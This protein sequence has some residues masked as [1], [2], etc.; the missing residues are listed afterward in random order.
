MHTGLG[1]DHSGKRV[2]DQNRRAVPSIQHALGGRYRFGQRR[3]RILYGRGVEPRRL[4]PLSFRISTS[5][6]RTVRAQAPR[7]SPFAGVEFAPM[8][9]VAIRSHRPGMR[10]VEKARLLIILISPPR[11]GRNIWLHGVG[12]AE[13][14]R[15]PDI[16]MSCCHS[17]PFGRPG[18]SALH[19]LKLQQCIDLRRTD[20]SLV[21]HE[22]LVVF[23]DAVT[24]VEIVDHDPEE[25]LARS[26]EPID[27]LKSCA[28]AEVKARYRVDAAS[29]R[30]LTR[31]I[32]RAKLHQGGAQ[33]LALRQ[34]MP[35][36]IAFEFRATTRRRNRFLPR[37][38]A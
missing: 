35:P 12:G 7:C 37:A 18:A 32:W 15:T 6:H 21:T 17:P 11:I 25:V 16:S 27:P 26:A 4:Q 30:R 38:A 28:V 2:T 24:V 33:S 29:R 31:Q 3:Q 1:D 13:R 10:A 20:D 36:T 23:L 19:G 9:R 22:D 8:P 5:C 14:C 34:V